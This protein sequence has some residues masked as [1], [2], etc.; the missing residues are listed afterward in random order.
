MNVDNL[1]KYA[2][3]IVHPSATFETFPHIVKGG[4][5]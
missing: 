4:P 2:L 1:I 3:Q 5:S